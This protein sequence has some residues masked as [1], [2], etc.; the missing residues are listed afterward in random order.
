M[1]A[2]KNI[3]L[4]WIT[5]ITPSVICYTME[6]LYKGRIEHEKVFDIARVHEVITGIQTVL[7]I[8]LT[9]VPFYSYRFECWN[10]VGLALFFIVIHIICIVCPVVAIVYTLTNWSV[11]KESRAVGWFFTYTLIQLMTIIYYFAIMVKLVRGILFFHR[12]RKN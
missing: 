10:K 8:Y 4:F 1:F 9:F 5:F 7:M 3:L 11:M 12:S 2:Q 6:W